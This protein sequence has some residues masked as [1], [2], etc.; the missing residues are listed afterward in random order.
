M[1]QDTKT[2]IAIILFVFFASTSNAFSERVYCKDIYTG[3]LTAPY[4]RISKSKSCPPS[5]KKI[6]K[7]E[8][9]EGGASSELDFN[10]MCWM[11][12]KKYL[13]EVI[14]T[15]EKKQAE[16]EELAQEMKKQKEE[17][18]QEMK[19]QKIDSMKADC[20][21]LG[22]TD[23]TEGMGNC[24]LKLMELAKPNQV[25]ISNP[26]S[27]SNS[28]STDAEMLRIEK[29]RLAMEKYKSRQDAAEKLMDIGNCWSVMGDFSPYC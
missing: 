17:L 6:T 19:K 25:V 2:V 21:D 28:S 20:R 29:E 13:E 26:S 9:C 12:D 11:Y 4:D 22:F 1:Q 24:V 15:A 18:A 10:K 3:K 8:Y 7:Q 23:G 16:K 5:H 14:E 27:G